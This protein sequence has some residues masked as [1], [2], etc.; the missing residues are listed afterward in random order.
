MRS[1]ILIIGLLLPLAATQDREVRVPLDGE[2]LLV[3]PHPRALKVTPD[4]HMVVADRHNHRFL[5]FSP[6]GKF[7]HAFG[8]Q[9]EG[10]GQFKRWFGEFTVGLGN[11]I[12]QVDFWGGNRGISVFSLQG[13]LERFIR[14]GLE[15]NF[16]PQRIFLDRRGEIRLAVSRGMLRERKGGFQYA[17]AEVVFCALDGEGRITQEYFRGREYFDFSDASGRGWPAIPHR[18]NLIS[19]WCPRREIIAWQKSDE[20]RVHLYSVPGGKT[21]SMPNGFTRRPLTAAHIRAWVKDRMQLRG[22]QTFEPVY[23]KLA[24]QG[25][26]IETHLPVVDRLFFDAAGNL[27]A[28]ARQEEEERWTVQCFRRDFALGR[29][30]SVEHLPAWIG[31]QKVYFLIHDEDEDLYFLEIHP[32][33]HTPWSFRKKEAQE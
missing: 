6:A 30:L 26:S 17:G 21:R 33:D 12:Y 19:A 3:D 11:R 28:A 24:R 4:G 13:K 7:L 8:E 20:D 29:R 16:G 1:I 31:T 14:I 9:G 27:Y 25:A 2:C 23:R 22:Y 32:C 10:P 15:E 5:V 18:V